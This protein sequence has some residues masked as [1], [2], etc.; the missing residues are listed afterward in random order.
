MSNVSR[1]FSLS[2]QNDWKRG[3]RFSLVQF[4][5]QRKSNYTIPHCE[6]AEKIDAHEWKN[7]GPFLGAIYQR[8]I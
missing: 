1:I 5:S 7:H 4:S 2:E 8:K 6:I 3:V